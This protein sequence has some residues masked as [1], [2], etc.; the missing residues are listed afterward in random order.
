MTV[1]LLSTA[2]L[3]VSCG[4]DISETDGPTKVLLWE[5]GGVESQHEWAVEAVARFNAHHDDIKVEFASRDWWTQRETLV[6]NTIVGEGPD[7]IRVHHKYA[8]EFGEIGGLLPLETFSDWPQI[9]DRYFTNMLSEVKYDGQHFGIPVTVLPFVLAINGRILQEH[10]LKVPRTWEDIRTMGPILKASGIHALTIPGGPKGDTSY[11]FVP[12]L[13]KAGGRVLNKAMTKAL[14][15]GPAGVATLEFLVDLQSNGFL[16]EGNA[17]Y[18]F[19]ENCAHWIS[20]RALLSVEG[21][22]FQN[23]VTTWYEFDLDYLMLRPLPQPP[24]PLEP[25]PAK[26]LI[27]VVMVAIP[28][29]T[30]VPEAAWTVLKELYVYDPVWQTA[31]PKQSGLPTQKSAFETGAFEGYIDI[32]IMADEGARALGWPPHPA[33]TQ[34]SRHIAEAANAAFS[35]IKTPKQALDDAARDVNELLSDY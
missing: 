28:S 9:R 27:D 18:A 16:P 11:R 14:F 12:L 15:N 21:P 7:I 32:D 34:I 31:D 22:W 3:F 6:S 29:Y 19:D 20:E 24:Q 30:E 33:V 23:T 1:V 2:C 13:Y 5:F 25:N 26:T 17:A 8:V 35:G 4:S 10:G